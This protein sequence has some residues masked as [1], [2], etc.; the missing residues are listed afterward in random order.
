MPVR[1]ARLVAFALALFFLT[2]AVP[3]VAFA[4]DSQDQACCCKDKTASCC[5]RSHHQKFG[6]GLSSRESCCGC[7]VWVR[8]NQPVAA[9]TVRVG[10]GIALRPAAVAVARA[11]RF[12]PAHHDAVLFERPPPSS[13]A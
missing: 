4:Q 7:M 11:T 3:V 12:A 6:L 10:P 1:T 2:Q 8:H 13:I 5:R 9:M